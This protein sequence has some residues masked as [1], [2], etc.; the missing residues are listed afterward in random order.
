MRYQMVVKCV[1]TSVQHNNSSAYQ[2]YNNTNH[3]TLIILFTHRLYAITSVNARQGV[4]KLHEFCDT[5][6]QHI[7]ANLCIPGGVS[8][9]NIAALHG[10][11]EVCMCRLFVY[12][13]KCG[14]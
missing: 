7:T 8:A 9:L 2:H 3:N 12:V 1:I 14:V 11:L 6:F 5:Y 13:F 10:N 4:K